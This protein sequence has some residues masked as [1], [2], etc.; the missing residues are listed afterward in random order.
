MEKKEQREGK[1]GKGVRLSIS[2]GGG[3]GGMMVDRSRLAWEGGREGWRLA[4][5]LAWNGSLEQESHLLY[6]FYHFSKTKSK[7]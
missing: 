4:G 2:E 7:T 6:P 5:R 3:D 1:G